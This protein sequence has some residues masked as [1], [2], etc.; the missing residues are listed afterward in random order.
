[1]TNVIIN[2]QHNVVSFKT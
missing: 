2:R 1:M